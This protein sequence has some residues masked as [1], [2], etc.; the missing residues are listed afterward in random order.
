MDNTAMAS[1]SAEVAEKATARPVADLDKPWGG[2]T[3][4]ETEAA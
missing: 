4:P 3:P 1:E 2:D